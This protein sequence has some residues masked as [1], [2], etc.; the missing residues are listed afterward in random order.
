M[1]TE[2]I[3]L[4]V[5]IFQQRKSD[6]QRDIF[7]WV[8]KTATYFSGGTLLGKW[9]SFFKNTVY[10]NFFGFSAKMFP[11]TAEVFS[12]GLSKLCFDCPEECFMEKDLS[13]NVFL[14]LLDYVHYISGRVFKRA[15]YVPKEESWRTKVFSWRNCNVNVNFENSAEQFWTLSG[16]SKLNFT[17]PKEQFQE[18]VNEKKFFIDFVFSAKK[19]EFLWEIL[20][21]VVKAATRLSGGR[22][23]GNAKKN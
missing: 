9:K 20:G 6:F 4:S 1:K 7:G 22:F 12:V 18:N 3:S 14:S 2:N 11:S 16:L 15:F 17:S 10:F 13:K 23:I 21:R 5:A 19:T 8:V